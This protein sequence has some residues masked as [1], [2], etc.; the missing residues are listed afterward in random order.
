MEKMLCEPRYLSEGAP[1]THDEAKKC[2]NCGAI[3]TNDAIARGCNKHVLRSRFYSSLLEMAYEYRNHEAMDILVEA[4][5]NVSAP[6]RAALENRKAEFVKY[7]L[8]HKADFD[9]DFADQRQPTALILASRLGDLELVQMLIDAGADVHESR[10]AAEDPNPLL[11]A[12]KVGNAGDAD[13]VQLL[14][15][16][17]ADFDDGLPCGFALVEMCRRDRT[18]MATAIIDTGT[19]I[20]QPCETGSGDTTSPLMAA[21]EMGATAT[22]QMLLERGAEVNKT[23][24]GAFYQNALLAAVYLADMDIKRVILDRGANAATLETWRQAFRIASQMRD[25]EILELLL[26]FYTDPATINGNNSYILT[27][28]LRAVMTWPVQYPD[29]DLDQSLY[30]LLRCGAELDE[31]MDEAL[32]AKMAEYHIGLFDEIWMQVRPY[33]KQ[34]K[35]GWG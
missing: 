20:N 17:G 32:S 12:A 6:L 14:L 2:A 21:I 3:D 23:V 30:S 18:D 16:H 1:T 15:Q 31:E 13:L 8:R 10:A 29:H 7:L 33:S 25:I 22:I 26:D 35:F 4:G 11:A 28:V 34:I 24:Q 19:D 9:L 5:A 27:E